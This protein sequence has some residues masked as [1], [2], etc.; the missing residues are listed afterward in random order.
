[1]R[2]MQSGSRISFIVSVV[3]PVFN[4]RGTLEIVLEAVLK[5]PGVTVLVTIADHSTDGSFDLLEPLATR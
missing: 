4:K 5:Q 1:M 2:R 3:M